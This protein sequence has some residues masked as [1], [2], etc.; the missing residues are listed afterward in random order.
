[1]SGLINDP[2]LS[3]P[4][5]FDVIVHYS[6]AGESVD[7]VITEHVKPGSTV[8]EETP[9][10]QIEVKVDHSDTTVD[11]VIVTIKRATFRKYI[12]YRKN[13]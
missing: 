5:K 2:N 8:M 12:N 4:V 9:A 3:L 10:D 7:D 11:S 6:E 13:A 1:M